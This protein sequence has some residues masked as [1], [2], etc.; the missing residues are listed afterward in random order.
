MLQTQELHRNTESCG[1]EA[2][3]V[4]VLVP[5][6]STSSSQLQQWRHIGIRWSTTRLQCSRSLRNIDLT[7]DKLLSRTIRKTKSKTIQY[8]QVIQQS[9]SHQIHQKLCRKGSAETTLMLLTDS[10]YPY[11]INFSSDSHKASNLYSNS[12]SKE[13]PYPSKRDPTTLKPPIT[14]TKTS[15]F[16]SPRNPKTYNCVPIPSC[17]TTIL[18]YTLPLTS[19]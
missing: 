13:T 1:A 15:V 6:R 5:F 4:T 16:N 12:F 8:H 17:V 7:I 11:S 18:G 2:S 19:Q 14:I 9:S 3:V 10:T